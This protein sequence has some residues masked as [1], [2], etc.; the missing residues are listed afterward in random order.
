MVYFLCCLF[1]LLL[2]VYWEV[3]IVG[4]GFLV[5][6][7]FLSSRLTGMLLCACVYTHKDCHVIICIVRPTFQR[8]V[9]HYCH[10]IELK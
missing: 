10:L 9:S 7:G 8:C 5:W 1:S 3:V 6:V 4:F 2:F